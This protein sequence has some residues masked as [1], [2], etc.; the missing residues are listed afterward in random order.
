MMRG[1]EGK[2]GRAGE[3]Q[4]EV[5][6]RTGGRKERKEKKVAITK[7]LPLFVF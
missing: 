3:E 5:K 1:F 2:K 4:A 6:E 7:V